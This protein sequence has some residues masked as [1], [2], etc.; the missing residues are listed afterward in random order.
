MAIRLCR[1]GVASVCACKCAAVVCVFVAGEQPAA[2]QHGNAAGA[3]RPVA[4]LLSAAPLPLLLAAEPRSRALLLAG[5]AL[6]ILLVNTC[7]LYD[8]IQSA[9]V[10]LTC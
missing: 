6:W 5:L 7:I 3:A 9:R 8:I 10:I 4:A 1:A 2:M